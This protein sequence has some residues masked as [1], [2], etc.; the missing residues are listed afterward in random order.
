MRNSATDL[1]PPNGTYNT[2]TTVF[3]FDVTG[4]DI[5][6]ARIRPFIPNNA[7]LPDIGGTLNLKA[8]AVGNVEDSKSYNI[9]FN[10]TGNVVTIDGNPLGDIVFNG[11]TENQ[12]LNANL[13]ANF[14]GQPQIDYGK[15]KFCRRKSAVSRRNDF[16][17]SPLAPFIALIRPPSNNITLS[18]DATG[19]V[20]VEGNLSALNASGKREFTIGKLKWFCRIQPFRFAD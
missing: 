19:K 4:K 3:N 5:D 11:K 1:L 2:D 13:T 20:F 6:F 15:R 17:N 9:N 8:K 10:G 14:E 16:N 12:Q 7:D 18:G